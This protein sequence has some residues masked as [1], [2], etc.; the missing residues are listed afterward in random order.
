M[1]SLL[2]ANLIGAVGQ[3]LIDFPIM[4]ILA[5][6]GA[7][8]L[9]GEVTTLFAVYLIQEGYIGWAKFLIIGYSSIVFQDFIFYYIGR[10]GRGTRIS[11]W[12]ENKFSGV[13]K[14]EKYLQEKTA[15]ALILTK[16][17]I[18]FGSITIMLSGWSKI[19]PKRFLKIN[20]IADA[21]W[22]G[23]MTGLSFV[24]IKIMGFFEARETFDSI[25][26]VLA[27]LVVLVFGFEYLAQK[28]F[29]ETTGVEKDS[30][31]A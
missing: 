14:L 8:I 21:L 16:Y 6:A 13:E 10:Y 11:S 27:G 26:L 30:T 9:R 15:K 29:T 4:G 23:T 7:F 2:S 17:T 20:A 19:E 5:M 18:G 3:F 28:Y 25:G 31:E 22:L 24:L 1:D 12:L